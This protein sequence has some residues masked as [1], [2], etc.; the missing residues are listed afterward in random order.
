MNVRRLILL[1]TLLLGSALLLSC[2]GPS[3][4][5]QADGQPSASSGDVPELSDD[6]I[7][8]RIND[9]RVSEI[10]EESG[11]GQPISWR[12]FEE[13]PKEITIV[14]KQVNGVQATVILDV[15]TQSTPRAREPRALAGQI[16]T[17]WELS[18][19]WVLRQWEIVRTENIS[20]KY[21]NLPKPAAQNSNN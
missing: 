13:E 16:R 8:Q 17:E 3:S 2:G 18:S 6:I 9:S 7:R 11:T 4:A 19:G 10:P 5:P 20:M 14:E 21:K 1:L 15:K 12:F